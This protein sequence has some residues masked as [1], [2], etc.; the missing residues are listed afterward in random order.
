MPCRWV[1][2]PDVST[3]L[4]AFFLRYK[5]RSPEDVDA[6]SIVRQNKNFNDIH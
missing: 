1:L 6:A 3:D 2:E 5:Q 4:A